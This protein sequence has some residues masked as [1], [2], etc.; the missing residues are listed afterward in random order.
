MTLLHIAAVL[1]IVAS[2][3]ILVVEAVRA[4]EGYEDE[5]GFHLGRQPK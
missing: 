5:T 2:V 1:L 4:P 3:I